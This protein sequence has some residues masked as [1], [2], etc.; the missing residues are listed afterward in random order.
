[1]RFYNILNKFLVIKT[2][3]SDRKEDLEGEK[4]PKSK[5]M[6]LFGHDLIYIN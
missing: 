6:G 2:S 3:V 4:Q 5:I 1:M